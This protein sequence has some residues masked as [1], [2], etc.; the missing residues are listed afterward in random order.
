M[1]TRVFRQVLFFTAAITS[2]CL[3]A[4]P[5]SGQNDCPRTPQINV[6][7]GDQQ[8]FGQLGNPQ[9]FVNVLGS[10]AP[11]ECIRKLTYSLNGGP[12]QPLSIGSDKRRLARPGDF[13]LEIAL[14]D[15]RR[16]A[17]QVVITAVDSAQGAVSRQVNV[18]YT[19]GKKWPLPYAIDWAKVKNIQDVAQVVDGRWGL[20][21]RGVRTLEPYYDR[22]IAVGDMSW[23]DYE[24]TVEVTYHQMLPRERVRKAP[25]S[26]RAHA[27]LLLRWQGHWDDGKQPRVKYYPAGALAMLRAGIEW[28]GNRWVIDGLKRAADPL[29][30]EPVGRKLELNKPYLYKMRVETLL[31]PQSRYS[32]KAWEPDAPEPDNWDLTAVETA[33]DLRSGSLLLVVHHAD[34]TFGNLRVLSLGPLRRNQ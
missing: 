22:V 15:L 34:V 7:H 14:P 8:H 16:G 12:A 9:R 31:G 28:E 25:Y 29:A 4:R 23:T 26:H 30:E 21:A 1:T 18:D 33:D 2:L 27:S 6:W 13:N 32:V 24:V 10:V 11:A 5:G 19:P 20:S 3:I 17:N